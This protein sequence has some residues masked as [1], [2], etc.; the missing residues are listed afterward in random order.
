MVDESSLSEVTTQVETNDVKK[1][2]KRMIIDIL[3]DFVKT[4]IELN[5]VLC[6]YFCKLV[7]S[8][9]NSNRKFF[10]IYAF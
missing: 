8:L 6:G 7:N 9:I 10:N 3:F 4:D 5:P 2:P 1:A